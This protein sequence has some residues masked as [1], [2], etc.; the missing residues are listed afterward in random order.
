M[1]ILNY[2][3][4]QLD[5]MVTMHFSKYFVSTL[6]TFTVLR[7]Y[8]LIAMRFANKV[9]IITG[10]N[11]GIGAACA[12]YFAKEGALLALVGRRA[13]KF[14]SVIEKIKEHGVEIEPLI[15]VA[16]VSVDA[17]RIIS[18]TIDNYGRIDILINNAGFA[19]YDDLENM[20]IED[21]DK[22]MATNTRGAIEL[23][24]FALPHL[25][26]TKG[27]IVNVSSIAG[28][29]PVIAAFA[30]SMSKGIM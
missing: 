30:Y 22:V 9:T 16:D 23:T 4:I 19:I 25:L 20:K 29:V 12:E 3:W 1:C 2:S 5:G 18:E 11:S 26:E 21:Y 8:H 15:I 6:G 28:V 24:K 7:R 13:E 10:S 14:E 17:A 27:N